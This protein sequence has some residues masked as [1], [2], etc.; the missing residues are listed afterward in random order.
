MVHNITGQSESSVV[1]VPSRKHRKR[2]HKRTCHHQHH[3]SCHV[4]DKSEEELQHMFSSPSCRQKVSPV[5]FAADA[6]GTGSGRVTPTAL[7]PSTKQHSKSVIIEL[8]VK[9][10]SEM[11]SSTSKICSQKK[12]NSLP[13]EA[14]SLPSMPESSE[15]EMA[16][17]NAEDTME[18]LSEN[19]LQERKGVDAQE[20]GEEVEEVYDC[21]PQLN[22]L[23][24][25]EAAERLQNQGYVHLTFMYMESSL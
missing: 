8:P 23:A 15:K 11:E 6:P 21:R 1:D 22:I 24:E 12:D 18:Q 14:P 10:E 20:M 9:D 13:V 17:G 25:M 2:S 19:V 3:V 5:H 16:P 4:V 7:Q